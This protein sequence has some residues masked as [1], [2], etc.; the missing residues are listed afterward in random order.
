[1]PLNRPIPKIDTTTKLK[2][3]TNDGLTLSWAPVSVFTVYVFN[4]YTAMQSGAQV[5]VL[6]S[7]V[8]GVFD[9]QF[10][11]GSGGLLTI[12]AGDISISGGT[13]LVISANAGIKAGDK[14]NGKAFSG[15]P[16]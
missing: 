3:L 1:M 15:S 9:I 14:I 16:M 13:N 11:D 10:L 6:P 8:Q 4:E 5:I 2:N 12:Y 7:T